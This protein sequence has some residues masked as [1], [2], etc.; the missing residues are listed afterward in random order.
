MKSIKKGCTKTPKKGK[1]PPSTSKY[2][3]KFGRS[4]CRKKQ[5]SW[6]PRSSAKTIWQTTWISPTAVSSINP[7]DL[8]GPVS[9]VGIVS[10]ISSIGQELKNLSSSIAN[11]QRPSLAGQQGLQGQKGQEKSSLIVKSEPYSVYT[12]PNPRQLDASAFYLGRSGQQGQLENFARQSKGSGQFGQ[13]GQFSPK[14]D[15]SLAL[16]AG[17]FSQSK[18]PRQLLTSAPS[19]PLVGPLYVEGPASIIAL[20]HPQLKKRILFMSDLHHTIGSCEKSNKPLM[21]WSQYIEFCG[22]QAVQNN[23][24]IDVF[25]EIDYVY[26]DE[27]QNLGANEGYMWPMIDHFANLRCFNKQAKSIKQSCLPGL[28]FHYT[29]TRSDKS[30]LPIMILAQD[31]HTLTGYLRGCL[32]NVVSG[33]EDDITSATKNQENSLGPLGSIDSKGPLGPPDYS[34]MTRCLDNIKLMNADGSV[35][36]DDLYAMIKKS[37]VWKIKRDSTVKDFITNEIK[38]QFRSLKSQDFG[39]KY[40]DLFDMVFKTIEKQIEN[41]TPKV[42]VESDNIFPDLNKQNCASFPLGRLL[43]ILNQMIND[44][45]PAMKNLTLGFDYLPRVNVLL[46]QINSMADLIIAQLSI[47]MD[48]YVVGRLL[49][50]YVS[51]AIVCQGSKHTMQQLPA[52]LNLGFQVMG[53]TPTGSEFEFFTAGYANGTFTMFMLPLEYQKVSSNVSIINKMYGNETIAYLLGNPTKP[54]EPLQSKLLLF[55]EDERSDLY[56]KPVS[57]CNDISTWH[58]FLIYGT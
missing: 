55:D 56:K 13:G 21:S 2:K 49:K 29:D 8:A 15:E 54:N 20:Y 37:P 17:Q 31:C 45:E 25:A 9:S 30:I 22:K 5:K 28:R 58:N 48:M 57:Q 43:T 16:I 23:E 50:P 38:K 39:P 12:E 35:N 44:L 51:K 10:S 1:C 53:S 33:I 42:V 46:A 52:Y 19:G 41:R 24:T 34:E 27:K 6:T 32:E 7:T 4:C 14:I 47:V 18:Q 3:T 40:Q 26:Q 11:G 36:T